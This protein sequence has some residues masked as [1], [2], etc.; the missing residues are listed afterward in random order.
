MKKFWKTL[1]FAALGV[2][3]LSSCEDVPAPYPSPNAGNGGG[4]TNSALYSSSNLID[5]STHSITAENPWSQGANYAQATGYQDWDGTGSKSNK[6]VE[7]YLISPAFNTKSESGKVKFNF[8][9]TLRY[10][11]N[12]S[13]YADH[14]KIYIS[15][16]YDG[17]NFDTATWTEITDYKPAP[18]AFSDW[19]LYSSGDFQL[20]DE[21]V[22]QENVYIAFWFYAPASASTTWELKDFKVEDG[23]ANAE[24]DHGT[25]DVETTG[26][27]TLEAPYTVADALAIINAKAYTADKVYIKGKISSIGIAGKDG[28][29]TDLPGSSYGNATYF[30][31]DEGQEENPLEVYRGY[32]LGGEKM[33]TSDYIKVGDEVIVYGALTLFN[34]T[35]EVTTGSSIASLNGKTAEVDPKPETTGTPEGDGTLANPYNIAAVISYVQ[36][37]GADVTSPE[38][39]YVKGIVKENTT[40]ASTISQYGNMNFTMIDKGFENAVFQ[41][42]QVY[43]LESQKFT[44]VDAIKA[45]DEVVVYGKVV[46]YKGTTPETTGKG[47]A[48]VY[49]INGITDPGDLPDNPEDPDEP[50]EPSSDPVD[51]MTITSSQIISGAS[52]SV[53]LG[54][55]AYGQQAVAT[56]STWY[57]FIVNGAAFTG[58]R[59][60][61]ASDSNGGGIQ[62]QGNASDASKQGFIT[63]VTPF[64]PIKAITVKAHIASG[65]QYDPSFHLYAGMAT[66]PTGT[67]IEGNMSKDGNNYTFV[68]DLSS[69]DYTHFTIANDLT[70]VLYIDNFTVETK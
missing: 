43:S 63:N 36:S 59:I 42:Y 10:T 3:T 31:V 67:A 69:G 45:G 50:E 41:A 24:E 22:N 65:S 11:N 2:F 44:S 12:E 15:K 19:T 4:N 53:S 7:G 6:Q 51:G 26:E 48:H 40:T 47:S 27:G 70:G 38:E 8:Q 9:Q 49:S 20:P 21:F 14:S 32:G 1:M 46:Y 54:T 55:N 30:I 17:S 66:H 57:N 68:F 52:G 29:L 33:T 18:S 64:T 37:L 28:N 58:C 56:E 60:C 34:T 5:F 35:P 23:E 16:D 39:V 62:M 25:T 61:I 13:G